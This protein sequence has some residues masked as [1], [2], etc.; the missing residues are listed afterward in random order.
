[1]P[2]ADSQVITAPNDLG[3]LTSLLTSAPHDAAYSLRSSELAYV[4]TDPVVVGEEGGVDE[5]Q[6]QNIGK[7]IDALE[8]EP[9]VVKVW[10]NME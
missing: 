2:F 4:A 8:E 1:M 10:T 7:T 9:D 5:D 3:S 6:A